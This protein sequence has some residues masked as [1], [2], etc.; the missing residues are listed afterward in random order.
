MDEKLLQHY[1]VFSTYTY[2]GLYQDLLV[3]DLPDDVRELG[4]LVRQNIIHRTTLAE[5]NSGSNADL[6]FGDMIR[7]PWWR[8][9][10]DDILVTAAAMFAELYRR[11]QRGLV[12]DRKPEDK[13]VLTCRFVHVMVVS[14]L[15]SK[16]IPARVRSGNAP[17]FDMGELSKVSADHWIAQYWYAKESRW[18]TIDVDGS[19]SLDANFD[20]YDMPE[21]VFDFPADAWLAVRAGKDNPERFW[22]ALPIRGTIVILWSLFYDFH[23]LMNNECIYPHHPHCALPD[24]F[25][26]LT[27]TELAQI[28]HLARLMQEPDKNFD[29]LKH[30]WETNKEFRLLEGGLL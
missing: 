7:V 30:I 25:E 16:G 14:I 5:G 8:Q 15:R 17:Y 6:R 29:E 28:D 4:L 1:L 27:E 24:V 10:E 2:P 13:L 22:N 9:P 3:H 26:T 21:G 23:C 12:H 11:D 18:V 20:P 19:L